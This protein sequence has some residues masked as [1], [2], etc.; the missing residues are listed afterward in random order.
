MAR[1]APWLH[2]RPPDQQ[3]SQPCYPRP[4]EIA[5][6]GRSGRTRHLDLPAERHH[7]QPSHSAR[8]RPTCSYIHA[9]RRP[10]RRRPGTTPALL[11]RVRTQAEQQMPVHWRKQCAN[12]LWCDTQA[13]Q[14]SQAMRRC[15]AVCEGRVWQ[16]R[17]LSAPYVLHVHQ[18]GSSTITGGF[19]SSAAIVPVTCISSRTW[20]HCTREPGT[21]VAGC[22][23]ARMRVGRGRHGR[24]H[25]LRGRA[26][27]S[28]GSEQAA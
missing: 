22:N 28:R 27:R 26:E 8:P 13:D 9:A 11:T 25:E 21:M 14:R 19:Y 23:T 24:R 2:T 6:Y 18:R 16:A 1:R 3:L 17:T 7:R 10:A 20:N 4:R 12:A 5:S 15:C